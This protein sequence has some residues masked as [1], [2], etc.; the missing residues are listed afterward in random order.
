[1]PGNEIIG[2]EELS[3]LKKIFNQSNGVLFAHGFDKR[4]NNIFR[5]RNFEKKIENHFNSKFA[6]CVSSGTAAIKIA[7]KSCGVKHGDEVITQAFNFIAT[8]EAIL[9]LGAIPVITNIDES[10]NM[11]P[12]DLKMKISKKTKA[13]IPVHMLGFPA[14]MDE[15]LKI[16][17]KYKIKIIEDN[18]ESVGA[19]Y[20][21]K[22]LGT[23]GDLGILSFDFGK[24]ITTGEGGA[25]LTNNKKLHKFCKEYHDHGHELNPNYPR[26]EDTVRIFGFNYRMTEMQGAVGLA[27]IKK[28]NKILSENKY[29]YKILENK[30][31]D[32]FKIRLCHKYSEPSYDTFIFEIKNRI[33]RKKIINFLKQKKIGTKNV[34]DAIKWHF[35]SYWSHAINKKEI[36]SIKKSRIKILNHLAIPI[37][38]KK[39]KKTYLEI[40]NFINNI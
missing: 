31:K 28:L 7:L 40:A 20:K 1:M 14:K 27:Q 9:D 30:I 13:V 5:V 36:K 39:S 25:I 35:A 16:C 18:C 32:K 33:K 15:I 17:K 22:K 3:E 8:I 24:N 6:Q 19:E 38:I 26:G 2:K 23:L 21:D 34:P 10:L 12:K 37:F 29:R 11:C 4:R